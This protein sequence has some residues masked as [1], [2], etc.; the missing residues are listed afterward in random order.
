MSSEVMHSI[1]FLFLFIPGCF[2]QHS[3]LSCL[4]TQFYNLMYVHWTFSSGARLSVKHIQAGS[5]AFLVP[6][7][8]LSL[9]KKCRR[10]HWVS[11]EQTKL[12][13]RLIIIVQIKYVNQ[14]SKQ[15]LCDI[16]V[17]EKYFNV[18][19][20]KILFEKQSFMHIIRNPMQFAWEIW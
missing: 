6:R 18:C 14:Y 15:L 3:H 11:T 17:F 10:K 13:C 5:W 16:N 8:F 2:S 7:C 19:G 9:S 12:N 4:R 1:A 20:T